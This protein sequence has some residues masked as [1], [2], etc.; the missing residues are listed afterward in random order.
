MF[1]HLASS[2]TDRTLWERS[3]ALMARS[4]L[5]W[6]SFLRGHGGRVGGAC[7]IGEVVMVSRRMRAAIQLAQAIVCVIAIGVPSHAAAASLDVGARSALQMFGTTL[8]FEVR[9]WGTLRDELGRAVPYRRVQLTGRSA[10]DAFETEVMSDASGAFRHDR[11]VPE[12][13]WEIRARFAGDFYLDGS[14]G[15][16]DVSVVRVPARL[17]VL[18]PAVIGVDVS[19]FEVRAMLTVAGAPV[20]GAPMEAI[21]GCGVPPVLRATDGGGRSVGA[22]AVRDQEGGECRVQVRALGEGRFADVTH[23]VAVRRIASPVI[24]L[25]ARYARPGPFADG[26]WEIRVDARDASGPIVGAQLELFSE[27]VSFGAARSDDAGEARFGFSELALADGAALSVTLFGDA[28]ALRLDSEPLVLRRPPSASRVFGWVSAAAV[29]LLVLALGWAVSREVRGK[30]PVTR[31]RE[32]APVSDRAVAV[33]ALGPGWWVAVCDADSGSAIASAEVL[34]DGAVVG[35]DASGRL[36]LGEAEAAE[37]EVRAAGYV[38][39]RV[40][41]RRPRVGRETVV[42]LRSIR[43]EV[44]DVL[45]SV[46]AELEGGTEVG[47]WGVRTIEDVRRTVGGGLVML[48]RAPQ[49]ARLQRQ[50]LGRLLALSPRQR[51]D[52][53]EALTLLVDAVYFGGRGTDDAVIELARALAEEALPAGHVRGAP[54][55][56]SSDDSTAPGV[57]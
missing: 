51:V 49:R 8:G 12:G 13:A 4:S 5:E 27:G 55:V 14:D 24:G 3:T 25:E 21:A 23:A 26:A 6:T 48:R 50:E 7:F 36:L 22:V 17:E 9:V 43:A 52:A 46:V 16:V 40:S 57:L 1:G 19:S 33:A 28:G 30:R 10:T 47:W 2:H 31:V 29:G 38:P 20:P 37:L 45:R 39:A 34:W 15:V 18:V 42:R 54:G 11:V 44:R 41:L 53:F 32:R 56:N 35:L